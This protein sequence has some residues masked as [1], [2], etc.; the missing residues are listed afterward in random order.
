LVEAVIF[1]FIESVPVTL[2]V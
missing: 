2:N 1:V